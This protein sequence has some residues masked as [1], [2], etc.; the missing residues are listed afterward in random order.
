MFMVYLG[1]W[2]IIHKVLNPSFISNVSHVHK[3]PQNYYFLYRL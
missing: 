1:D 2:D 3:S